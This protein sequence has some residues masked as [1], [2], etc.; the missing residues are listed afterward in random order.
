M[1]CRKTVGSKKRMKLVLHP[2]ISQGHR[3]FLAVFSLNAHFE[4]S[5]KK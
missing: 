3:V 1:L 4:P 5:S 2:E